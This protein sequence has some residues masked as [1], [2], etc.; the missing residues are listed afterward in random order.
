VKFI[1]IA[2]VLYGIYFIFFKKKNIIAQA[3][4]QNESIS[5]TTQCVACDIYVEIDDAIMSDG[6][7]Y[8]SKE[9]LS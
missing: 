9:C 6:K 1:I 4:K 8:C 7:Y 2:I 5:D 3:K